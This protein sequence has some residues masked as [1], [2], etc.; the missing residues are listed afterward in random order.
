MLFIQ[1]LIREGIQVTV[2]LLLNLIQVFQQLFVGQDDAAGIVRIIHA[3]LVKG[4]LFIL[5][6]ID[7][8]FVRGVKGVISP[9]PAGSAAAQGVPVIGPDGRADVQEIRRDGLSDDPA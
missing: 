1:Q 2:S 6:G 5:I 7:E 3:F 8:P 9:S 4:R